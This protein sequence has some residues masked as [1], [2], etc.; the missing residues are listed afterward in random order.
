MAGPA[1]PGGVTVGD[2]ACHHP[3]DNDL[4]VHTA[5]FFSGALGMSL[6]QAISLTDLLRPHVAPQT[7][8][9]HV[10]PASPATEIAGIKA[11][12]KRG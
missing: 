5:D 1:I 6:A 9:Q 3:G 2:F 4:H 8:T 10:A 11:G 7:P 12:M